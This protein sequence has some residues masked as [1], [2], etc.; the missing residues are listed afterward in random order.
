[1]FFIF[2]VTEQHTGIYGSSKGILTSVIE[3]PLLRSEIIFWS[4][5][6]GKCGGRW[7]EGGNANVQTKHDWNK[8]KNVSCS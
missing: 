3:L 7:V 6:S 1:M 4:K 5:L 8:V 2:T